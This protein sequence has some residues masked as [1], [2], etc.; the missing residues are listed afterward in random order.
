MRT[1]SIRQEQFVLFFV[2]GLF[3]VV[4]PAIQRR[5][6]ITRGWAQRVAAAAAARRCVPPATR[7][8][9]YVQASDQSWQWTDV[10]RVHVP[11]HLR[12]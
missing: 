1:T 6:A 5:L 8:S 3:D 2:F 11:F 7:V 9:T 10:L 12:K 4:T